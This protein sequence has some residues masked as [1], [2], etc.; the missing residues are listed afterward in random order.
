MRTWPL[1]IKNAFSGLKAEI[2]KR[3]TA[4]LLRLSVLPVP[5]LSPES[6]AALQ[7]IFQTSGFIALSKGDFPDK[8]PALITLIRLFVRAEAVTVDEVARALSPLKPDELIHSGL[9]H[10]D[11]DLV[12]SLLQAQS[13]QGLIFFSDFRYHEHAE[14]YVLPVGP[15]GAHLAGIT[16]RR[17]VQSAL[18]LGCGCG[19]QSLLTAQHCTRV[20]ATDINPRA[21]AMTR[22][23]ADLNG[24]SNI[25]LLE[26]SYLEPV[27]GRR[28]DLMLANL[29]YVISPGKNLMYRDAQGDAYLHQLIREIPAFLT[30]GGYAQLISNWVRKKEDSWWGSLETT[31]EEL[32]MDAWLIHNG[33]LDSEEYADRWLGNDSLL[34][35]D[36]RKLAKTKDAWLQFFD[37]QGIERIAL[38]DII[39]RRRTCEQNWV[40]S[41][42]VTKTLEYPAGEQLARL[43]ETQDF[44]ASLPDDE[45]LLETVLIPLDMEV[46]S[47][48]DERGLRAVTTMGFNFQVILSPFTAEVIAHLDGRTRLNDAIQKTGQG[49]DDNPTFLLE[50][51]TLLG[52][53]MLAKSPLSEG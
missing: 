5:Q 52:L 3:W 51:Q 13:Y 37:D 49:M 34:K 2:F 35:K 22:L 17:P 39:L 41:A 15:S 28:F 31:L 7:K 10:Q 25:E 36:R 42:S 23:N 20:T 33:S 1:S 30:E 14:D 45:A 43:F 29:P 11:G 27:Q 47:G 4:G 26:G 21:L 9:L 6:A 24:A 38:G 18:D 8:S 32:G 44:L 50:I 19:L 40:C 16:I 53:G 46:Q 12:Q 48:E